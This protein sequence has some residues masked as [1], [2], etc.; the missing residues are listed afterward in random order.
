MLGFGAIG[1]IDDYAK[2]TKRSHRGL[3]AR[4]RLLAEFAI[5]GAAAAI[6]SSHTGHTLFCPSSK[7]PACISAGS[8][9]HSPPF[10]MVGAETR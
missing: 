8:T 10:M 6:I 4:G 3:S 5:A 7:T 2:V 9:S 1:F